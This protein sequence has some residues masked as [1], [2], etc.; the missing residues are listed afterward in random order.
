[1]PGNEVANPRRERR[2][3]GW[4][5]VVAG[6]VSAVVFISA[7]FFAGAYYGNRAIDTQCVERATPSDPQ[8]CTEIRTVCYPA[9][10]KFGAHC[11]K[12][13]VRVPC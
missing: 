10:P 6:V 11:Y 7:A 2:Y 4:A 9:G 3:A 1:M 8:T 12:H 5:R 13:V